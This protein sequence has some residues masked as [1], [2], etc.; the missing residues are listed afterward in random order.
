MWPFEK[1]NP[2]VNWKNLITFY[3][4][5]SCWNSHAGEKERHGNKQKKCSSESSSFDWRVDAACLSSAT[6]RYWAVLVFMCSFSLKTY[7]FF[8]LKPR[9]L[10]GYFSWWRSIWGN[11]W[12]MQVNVCF[13]MWGSLKYAFKVTDIWQLGREDAA[14]S[15]FFP[16]WYRNAELLTFFFFAFDTFLQVYTVMPFT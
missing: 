6:R 10:K 5:F 7:L 8:C 12:L 9:G 14:Q 11:K 1:K 13:F 15:Y 16:L 3:T 2:S 4:K